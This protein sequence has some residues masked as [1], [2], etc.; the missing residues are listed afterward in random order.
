MLNPLGF[1]S[2]SRL[3]KRRALS[4]DT[5]ILFKSSRVEFGI[6]NEWSPADELFGIACN[7]EPIA[8]FNVVITAGLYENYRLFGFGYRKLPASTSSYHD[9]AIADI[10]QINRTGFR[11]TVAPSLKIKFGPVIIADNFKCTRIDLF[12]THEYFYDMRT[13]LPHYSHDVDL[14][15]DVIALYEWSNRLRT[16]FNYNSL[17]IIKTEIRQQKLGAMVIITPSHKSLSNLFFLVTSGSYLESKYRNHSPYIA[18]LGGFE[19]PLARTQSPKPQ[20]M[21][22]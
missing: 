1:L 19:I 14:S 20:Q 18:A 13:S 7:Y 15:N 6:I 8:I 16:G 12:S 17:R 4:H 22:H 9:S 3:L 5:G 10:A 21:Q 11:A 2:D